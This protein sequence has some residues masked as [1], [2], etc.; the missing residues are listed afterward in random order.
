WLVAVALF[1][2]LY[3]VIPGRNGIYKG[4]FATLV[5]AIPAALA[6]PLLDSP[7][8]ARQGWLFIS[9]ELALML[10]ATGLLIDYR[11]VVRSGMR[12]KQ[13]GELYYVTSIQ[14]AIPYVSAVAAL[15][16]AIVQQLTANDSSAAL[17]ELLNHTQHLNPPPH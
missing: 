6:S 16:F 3:P 17:E 5:Y 10:M 14:T 7:A 1:L 2:I 12:W 8:D 13:L 15:V 11:T 9:A 4:F